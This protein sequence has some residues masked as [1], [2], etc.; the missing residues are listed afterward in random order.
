MKR[1]ARE[2]YTIVKESGVVKALRSTYRQGRSYVGAW[3]QGR[4]WGKPSK[5]RGWAT[6]LPRATKKKKKKKQK[7]ISIHEKKKKI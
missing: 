2:S 1:I 7:K 3:G 6:P 5:P 4:F